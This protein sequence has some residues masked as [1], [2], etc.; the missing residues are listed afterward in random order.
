[1]NLSEFS[2]FVERR[3][4]SLGRYGLF[5]EAEAA[6]DAAIG[7]RDISGITDFSGLADEV[8]AALEH[9]NVI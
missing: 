7:G 1:M 2:G 6:I 5:D 8:T 3:C 4:V 9:V